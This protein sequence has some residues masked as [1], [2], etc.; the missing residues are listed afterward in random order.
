VAE[1]KQL[2]GELENAVTGMLVKEFVG[3]IGPLFIGI[4][5]SREVLAKVA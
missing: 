4:E 1:I 3:S 5:A 2:A